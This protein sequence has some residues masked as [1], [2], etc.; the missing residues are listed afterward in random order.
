[1]CR[2]CVAACLDGGVYEANAESGDVSLIGRH[3]S[4]ASGVALLPSTVA[5]MDQTMATL[6]F[7]SCSRMT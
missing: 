2:T 5:P 6:A 3:E 4:Y 7:A 1:M